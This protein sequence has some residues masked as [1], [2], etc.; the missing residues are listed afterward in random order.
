MLSQVEPPRL[1]ILDREIGVSGRPAAPA[2]ERTLVFE[3][4]AGGSKRIFAAIVR[5]E[6]NTAGQIEARVGR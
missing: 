6:S 4:H 5:R 1:R 3:W 2:D